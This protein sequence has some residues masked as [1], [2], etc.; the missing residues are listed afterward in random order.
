M[1]DFPK[2]L[3]EYYNFM[4]IYISKLPLKFQY[5]P[6][7]KYIGS[8][9]GARRKK[10]ILYLNMKFLKDKNRDYRLAYFLHHLID[11]I[12]QVFGLKEISIF[13]R[14]KKKLNYPEFN[15]E[16]NEVIEFVKENFDEILKEIFR[17]INK[18]NGM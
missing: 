11:Y 12:E 1:I 13:E 9:D 7:D 8:H 14:F 18:P 3:E 5:I 16:R 6:I 10:T 17:D 2:K 15:N 4:K